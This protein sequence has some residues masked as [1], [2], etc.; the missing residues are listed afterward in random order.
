[1]SK[2]WRLSVGADFALCVLF[3]C[4]TLWPFIAHHS[5]PAYQHDWSWSPYPERFRDGFLQ[6]ISTWNE[7]GFGHPNPFAT[8]NPLAAITVT[9]GILFPPRTG[10]LLLFA[11]VSAVGGLGIIALSRCLSDNFVAGRV[12][13]FLYIASPVFFNKTSAGQLAYLEAYALFPWVVYFTIRALS[14]GKREW[15]IGLALTSALECVQPQFFLYGVIDAAV[16]AIAIGGRRAPLVVATVIVAETVL[17]APG[18][19]ALT[20]LPAGYGFTIAHPLRNWEFLQSAA[21]P[22]ALRLMGYI[23][24]Y[25]SMA[26]DRVAWG[27]FSLF[28]LWSVPLISL[29]G[30]VR[31]YR[32][33]V[34]RGMLSLT[35]IG[36][37]LAMGTRGPLALPLEWS[38]AHLTPSALLREFYHS[39]VL[40]SCAFAIGTSL[41]ISSWRPAYW[42]VPLMYIFALM[43]LAIP[44]HDADLNF[45]SPS[46]DQLQ[47]RSYIHQGVEGRVLPLPFKM[48]LRVGDAKQ[49]GIDV[50]A[51]IDRAHML[52]SEYGMT[53]ELD[54]VSAMVAD[55]HERQA[56]DVLARD[57]VRYVTWRQEM[58]SAFP[59]AL[60]DSGQQRYRAR[61]QA[62]FNKTIARYRI[63]L[64][65]V[66]CFGGTCVGV[67]RH[68]RPLIDSADALALGVASWNRV[69]P[70]ATLA[71]APTPSPVIKFDEWASS[72]ADGWVPADAW[73][74]S[75]PLWDEIVSP[76]T[77]VGNRNS[78]S[79]TLS[80]VKHLELAYIGGPLQFCSVLCKGT[81]FSSVPSIVAQPERALRVRAGG[82]AAIATVGT[83]VDRYRPSHANLAFAMPSPW[84]V[85]GH[86]SAAGPALLILRNR[87]DGGW[88]LSG[89]RV[90]GRVNVDGGLNGWWVDANA[91]GARF[92]I[93]YQ[94]EVGF[95]YAAAAEIAIYCVLVFGFTLAVITRRFS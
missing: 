52:A 86:F 37:F 68:V 8:A 25:A 83:S 94:P 76:L 32:N 7:E 3:G 81:V 34:A 58:N 43:P 61:A 45:V 84:E 44:G 63:M 33:P 4:F 11:L 48:P 74:W 80:N 36:L 85:H 22:D 46:L 21:L 92:K 77:L 89:L 62:V 18:I 6:L 54:T 28:A 26:Y 53:P 1:M 29:A 23:I 64:R 19:Y 15:F 82:H 38:F 88:T 72:P 9:V 17:N 2:T 90:L 60:A 35:L 14:E 51:Y 79:V 73:R 41:A 13:A 12:A 49:S 10:L 95:L 67:L 27:Q 31:A 70:G 56:R 91:G 65:N 66:R 39:S 20:T 50:F 47:A 5:I 30:F 69:T 75:D 59:G 16:F 42:I 57:G 55:G 40:A 93:I 78:S 87:F 24:P 71:E